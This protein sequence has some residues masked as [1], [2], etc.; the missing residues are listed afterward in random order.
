MRTRNRRRGDLADVVLCPKCKHMTAMC[1]AS[2][3][4]HHFRWCLRCNLSYYVRYNAKT[5]RYKR[6]RLQ[7]GLGS[8][9][10]STAGLCTL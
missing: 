3:R 9:G 10:T 5:G 7:K 8:Y 1:A 4:L 2:D 6:L